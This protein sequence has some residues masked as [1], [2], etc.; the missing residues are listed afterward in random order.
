M[1]SF[2]FGYSE[3]EVL[4]AQWDI[5]TT[6][7]NCLSQPY[8]VIYNSLGIPQNHRRPSEAARSIGNWFGER[9]IVFPQLAE[10]QRDLAWQTECYQRLNA[11]YNELL[12]EPFQQEFSAIQREL[13]ELKEK[14]EQLNQRHSALQVSKD[15]ELLKSQSTLLNARSQ[16]RQEVERLANEIADLRQLVARQQ[17]ELLRLRATDKPRTKAARKTEGD[18]S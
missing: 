4:K 11:R 16:H 3:Q 12:G 15:S 9:L 8:V 17:E 6:F 1:P 10:C 2:L 5:I 13:S 14:Y 7:Q 18:A